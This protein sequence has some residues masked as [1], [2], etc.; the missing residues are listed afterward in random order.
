MTALTQGQAPD[1]TPTGIVGAVCLY[2]FYGTPTW[3]PRDPS[4]PSAPID[5]VRAEAVP[6]F[7]V[8]GASDSFVPAAEARR[9]VQR[10]DSASEQPVVFAELPGGQHTFDLYRSPRFEAVIDGIEAF[11]AW[12]RSM[13]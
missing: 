7:V 12:V 6:F 9:F 3:I 5:L 11:T 4:A 8:H 2:G 1:P 13:T 10:L